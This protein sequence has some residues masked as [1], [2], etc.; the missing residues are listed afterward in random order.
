MS[1]AARRQ[2]ATLRD[3]VGLDCSTLTVTYLPTST[4]PM[5][6]PGLPS[7]LPGDLSGG[8]HEAR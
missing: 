1:A 7:H 8:A 4:R 6:R 3:A 2:A 5:A